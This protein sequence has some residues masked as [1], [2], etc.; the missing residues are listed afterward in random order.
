[1]IRLWLCALI[2]A[3]GPSTAAAWIKYI[4]EAE[5]FII[6]FPSD[7]EASDTTFTTEYHV[8]APARV[9]SS[10]DAFGS[11]SVTVVDYTNIESLLRERA[12]RTGERFRGASAVYDVLGSVAFAA[13]NIRRAGGEIT[14]DGWS[15]VDHIT[16]HQ[17]QITNEDQSRSFY[18]IFLHDS[19]L[20]ILEATAP[21]GLPPAGQFQQSLGILDDEGLR[22]RYRL[23]ADGNRTRV[24][25]SYEWTDPDDPTAE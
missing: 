1:M 22:V 3:L 2:I 12:E 24:D 17:L 8:E 14:F 16:G 21:A 19:R 18:G 4:D 23:D 10:E 6:N 20:Y 5:R 9:Y 11:Y 15:A 13:A 25:S 7:P